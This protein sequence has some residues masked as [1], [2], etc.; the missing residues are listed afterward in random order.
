M[1]SEAAAPGGA[2]AAL[3]AL[4]AG[5]GR[6][7]ALGAESWP[8]VPCSPVRPE[9]DGGP[10]PHHGPDGGSEFAEPRAG[11]AGRAIPRPQVGAALVAVAGP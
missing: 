9:P 10:V 7:S 6:G 5:I 1:C 4:G 3:Q 11:A 2:W 8:S